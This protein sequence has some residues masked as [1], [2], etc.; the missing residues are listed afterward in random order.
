[1]TINIQ[2]V[3]QV[4]PQLA[5]AA[6]GIPTPRETVMKVVLEVL[7]QAPQ[8]PRSDNTV[9]ALRP[10]TNT[11]LVQ[12]GHRVLGAPTR[13]LVKATTLKAPWEVLPQTRVLQVGLG[14]TTTIT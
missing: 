3:P 12:E 5:P 13:K 14:T 2:L 8:Q 7:P 10:Q 1:M 9:M 4:R 11:Q 6:I